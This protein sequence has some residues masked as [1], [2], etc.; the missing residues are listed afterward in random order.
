MSRNEMDSLAASAALRFARERAAIREGVTTSQL[1]WLM[2]M[3]RTGVKQNFAAAVVREGGCNKTALYSR[4]LVAEL[5]SEW[6]SRQIAFPA[7]PL[8]NA[9]QASDFLLTQGVRLS[10]NSLL[11]YRSQCPHLS[12]PTIRMGPN[13]IAGKVRYSR[14]ELAEY[15]TYRK[16]TMISQGARTD[17][18]KVNVATE[19][20][21][22]PAAALDLVLTKRETA[23]LL[24]V[25]KL[26]KE[27]THGEDSES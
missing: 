2:N 4:V 12:P 5:L 18:L 8:M 20:L 9:E 14:T 6:S 19:Q 11:W 1:A 15:A 27:R 16:A 22:D 23:A 10:P 21:E 3:S 17:L 13:P 7:E 26:L 25:A 24:R